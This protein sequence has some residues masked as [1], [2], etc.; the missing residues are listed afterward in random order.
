MQKERDKLWEGLLITEEPEFENSQAFKMTNDGKVKK[1]LL[2]KVQIQG[3]LSKIWSRDEADGD[4]KSSVKTS[5][6]SKLM[7]LSTTWSHKGPLKRLEGYLI[8]PL[9]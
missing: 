3:T 4:I 1:W 8:D 7:S 9:N 2:N 6:R 5:E